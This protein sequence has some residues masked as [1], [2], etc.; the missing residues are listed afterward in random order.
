MYNL[1]IRR[2]FQPRRFRTQVC[3]TP[4]GIPRADLPS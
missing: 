3:A 2:Q 1:P 4:A